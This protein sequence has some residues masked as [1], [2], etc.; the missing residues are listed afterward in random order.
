M[1]YLRGSFF[2]F[3]IF[4]SF[5]KKLNN[6]MRAR[7][8]FNFIADLHETANTTPHSTYLCKI[9]Y[10]H[11]TP[12]MGFLVLKWHQGLRLEKL[13]PFLCSFY[14]KILQSTYY[15]FIKLR[16]TMLIQFIVYSDLHISIFKWF[17]ISLKKKKYNK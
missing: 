1:Y 13:N 14:I 10:Y 16:K 11:E 9:K 6:I 8:R 15:S 4:I 7:F 5:Y 3:L 2:F 17:L 12:K